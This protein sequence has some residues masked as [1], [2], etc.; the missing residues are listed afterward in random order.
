[1]NVVCD[2]FNLVVDHIHTKPSS[3]RRRCSISW[4]SMGGATHYPPRCL[5]VSSNAWR[6]GEATTVEERA[7]YWGRLERPGE[8]RAEFAKLRSS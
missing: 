8:I 2:S 4:G 3:V 5:E 7:A 6:R 1:M